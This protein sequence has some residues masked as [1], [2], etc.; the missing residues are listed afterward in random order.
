MSD[1]MDRDLELRAQA[2][3]WLARLRADDRSHA[4]EAGFHDWLAADPRNKAAFDAANQAWEHVGALN[5]RRKAHRRPATQ[6]RPQYDRRM[7]LAGGGALAAGIAGL[8]LWSLVEGWTSYTTSVGETRS[9]ALADGSRL[10]LDTDTVVRTRLGGNRRSIELLR[11]RAHFAV[12]KDPMRPFVVAAGSREVVA[13]GTAF[14]VAREEGLTTVL[15]LEGH[16]AVRARSGLSSEQLADMA[17]PGV[18]LTVLDNGRVSQ[19]RP[20]LVRLTAWQTGRVVFEQDTLEAAVAEMNR[21]NHHQIVL[22]VDALKPLRFSGVYVSG[23]PAAFATS[24][25]A[26][27]D[28]TVHQEANRTVLQPS[29]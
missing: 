1:Q 18:R 12:A 14:D 10:L 9:I 22:G 11:G 16:V 13:V 29:P 17:T 27:F 15:L 7:I 2:A 20:D 4:D 5:I 25:A 19:D 3:V 23:D 21:Y 28:L 24:V 6:R 8:G 26:L